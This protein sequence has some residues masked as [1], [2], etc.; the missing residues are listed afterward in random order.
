L[1]WEGVDKPG[2]AQYPLVQMLADTITWYLDNDFR[3]ATAS[4]P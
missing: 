2:R 3:V 1:A 4:S